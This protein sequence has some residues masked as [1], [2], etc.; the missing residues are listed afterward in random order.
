MKLPWYEEVEMVFEYFDD[1]KRA[2]SFF[3]LPQ[4]FD[5]KSAE[6][7]MTKLCVDL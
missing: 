7:I 5:T 6:S 3:D 2:A 4:A 1:G